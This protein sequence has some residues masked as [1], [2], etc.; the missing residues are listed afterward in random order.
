[1]ESLD[2]MELTPNTYSLASVYPN[3]FNPSTT[4]SFTLPELS[5][6]TMV[7]LDITGREITELINGSM[8]AG[9]HNLTWNADNQSSGIYFVKMVA[10]S[11]I[12]D[13]NREFIQTQK[14]ILAK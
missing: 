5:V 12:S 2:I 7:I 11:S 10:R 3:P 9:Y 14:L 4:V 6:V 13:V 8:Q 1:V